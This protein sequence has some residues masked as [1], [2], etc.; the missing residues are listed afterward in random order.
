VTQETQI[1]QTIIPHG[2]GHIGMPGASKKD[3]GCVQ[4]LAQI[5]NG[6]VPNS[7]EFYL[8]LTRISP[9]MW[10]GRKLPIGVIES[11]LP[12]ATYPDLY[13]MVQQMHGGGE[14]QIRVIDPNGQQQHQM[15]IT[16][17]LLS[18][19]PMS[20]TE[21]SGRML[22][23]I[24]GS[25]MMYGRP[26]MSHLPF[27]PN[28]TD[29]I[30]EL[31]NAEARLRAEESKLIQ[32]E[33]FE[34]RQRSVERKRVAE[35]E[36]ESRKGQAPAQEMLTMRNELKDALRDMHLSTERSMEKAVQGMKD[37]VLLMKPH[38]NGNTTVEMVKA[39]A[40]ILSVLL[41]K[42]NNSEFTEA[43][44]MTRDSQEKM[45]QMTVQLATAA[46]AKNDNL[47]Q[48]LIMNKLEA[49]STAVEQALE[50]REKGWKQ[51]TEMF[52]MMDE[53]RGGHDSGVINPEGGFWGNLGNVLVNGLNSLMSGGIR[54]GA[55]GKLLETVAGN[56]GKTP[57]QMTQG[58]VR[59]AAGKM[60][61]AAQFDSRLKPMQ[62]PMAAPMQLPMAALPVARVA[63]PLGKLFNAVL[64]I[65][66][67][68]VQVP[69]VE[70]P[71]IPQIQVPVQQ[72]PVQV[73]APAPMP[74]VQ[75]SAPAVE[76]TPKEDDGPSGYIN[77][78]LE[79]AMHDVKDERAAHNWLEFALDKW[80]RALL[81]QI[82]EA[83][84][85]DARLQVI[86]G[87]ADAQLFQEFAQLVTDMNHPSRY[88]NFMDNLKQLVEEVANAGAAA[89]SQ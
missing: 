15:R 87:Y 42:N 27:D 41:A 5:F 49:P 35:R 26:A 51:A 67:A 82:A 36:V 30:R 81:K 75:T 19:P 44:K 74:P 72:A 50:M 70:L 40:P 71:Q 13:S 7:T 63:S 61:Q 48:T 25:G 4:Y 58:D 39:L 62:L 18:N 33:K 76:A 79:I 20:A 11:R 46:Q 64:E 12:V 80:P 3:M 83:P 78:M 37:L 6:E 45:A 38:D 28:D 73:A 47:I 66:P 10:E 43:I 77:E 59:Y 29:E 22:P 52:M 57:Q 65:Q 23:G 86:Q 24:G 31:R 1:R 32:E 2:P 54:G 53:L 16:I 88:S 34:D 17:D 8:T 85:D 56:L 84:N 21:Q 14:F 89:S 55:A 69:M 60:Q 68:G 9:V